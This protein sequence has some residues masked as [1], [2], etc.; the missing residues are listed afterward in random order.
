[1]KNKD[2]L[3][4]ELKRAAANPEKISNS[5]RDLANRALREWSWNRQAL[6]FAPL[7]GINLGV[8]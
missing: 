1:M 4:R 7:L 5:G 2:D 3:N 6:R 8:R